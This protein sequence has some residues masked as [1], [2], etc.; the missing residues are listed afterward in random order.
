MLKLKI[1]FKIIKK[2]FYLKLCTIR[3]R[4]GFINLLFQIF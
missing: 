2:E 3:P 1:G 4:T